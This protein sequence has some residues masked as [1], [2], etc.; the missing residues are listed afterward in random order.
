MSKKQEKCIIFS[1]FIFLFVIVC[2]PC[3]SKKCLQRKKMY[4]LPC[5]V[6]TFG[7][8]TKKVSE[9][10]VLLLLKKVQKNKRTRCS[11]SLV[12]SSTLEV[13]E[14]R[15]SRGMIKK[16]ISWYDNPFESKNENQRSSTKKT[17]NPRVQKINRKG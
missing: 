17:T 8:S 14:I 6:C 9:V 3:D 5:V 15:C 11:Q 4:P 16:D 1:F 7:C 10:Q 2:S 12:H 13:H